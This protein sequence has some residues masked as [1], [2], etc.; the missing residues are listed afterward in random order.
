VLLY[1]KGTIPYSLVLRED[2]AVSKSPSKYYG[3][4]VKPT[5]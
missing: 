5:Y 4:Y 1:V 2:N 3:Q